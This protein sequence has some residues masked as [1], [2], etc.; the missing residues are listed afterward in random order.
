[1]RVIGADVNPYLAMAGALASGLYGIR[2]K[3]ELQ[4]ASKGNGYKDYMHGTLPTTLNAATDAMK[5]SAI[6]SE[7]L[8]EKF[9]QHFVQTREWEWRQHLKPVT[10][11]EM[12]RYFEII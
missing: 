12:R 9:V 4:P 3:L 6:A 8:G 11:W 7:I 1:M 10:D 2:K 5:T